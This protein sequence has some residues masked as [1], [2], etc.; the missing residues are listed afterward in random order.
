MQNEVMLANTISRKSPTFTAFGP[1][2]PLVFKAQM[3]LETV[4]SFSQQHLLQLSGT[5]NIALQASSFPDVMEHFTDH[6]RQS[7]HASA[8]KLN[9]LVYNMAV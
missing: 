7:L 6:L 8:A 5:T 1:S 4:T 3:R 2:N 9:G